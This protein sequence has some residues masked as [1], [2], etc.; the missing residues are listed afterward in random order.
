MWRQKYNKALDV[1][2]WYLKYAAQPVKYLAERHYTRFRH[3]S[4]YRA[5]D[6]MVKAF[7]IGYFLT[8]L[9]NFEETIFRM[10]HAHLPTD[11]EK[12]VKKIR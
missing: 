4:R 9:Y 8:N 3:S 5:A 6:A 12:M 2:T 1:V 7:L 11:Y 10:D